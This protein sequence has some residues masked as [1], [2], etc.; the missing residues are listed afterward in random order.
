MTM[1][2]KSKTITYGLKYALATGN[3][4][5]SSRGIIATRDCFLFSLHNTG[6]TKTGV[7]Q[8]LNRLTF[9]STLSHLRRL[10]TP[11]GREGKLAKPRQLHNTH[12]G[13]ICPAETPEGQ[14]CGLVKNLALMTYVSVGSNPSP[15]LEI[16]EEWSLENLQEISPSNILKGTKIFV[17]GVWVGIHRNPERL[18]QTLR[19][20]RRGVH[21]SPEVSIVRDIREQELR[22]FTDAG[23][24]CRP[25]FVVDNQRLR[26][27][28]AHISEIQQRVSFFFVF[29]FFFFFPC[30]R[31][32]AN[33][34]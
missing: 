26:I 32:S 2:V 31:C 1:A 16:L 33:Q 24:C 19:S 9:S 11:I 15:I 18:V 6:P 22:I 13:M 30:L 27:K 29:F 8:V 12:W 5:A 7:A 10:N 25:L 21:I 28:K 14:A 3:W 17:N 20:L 34:A 4:G 23:R